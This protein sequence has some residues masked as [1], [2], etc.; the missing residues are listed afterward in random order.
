MMK[1]A[2]QSV[3]AFPQNS[4]LPISILVS[5]SARSSVVQPL[6]TVSTAKLVFRFSAVD[7][8]LSAPGISDICGSIV[9]VRTNSIAGNI[10]TNSF[11]PSK[12]G[13]LYYIY[14]AIYVYVLVANVYGG[15]YKL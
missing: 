12:M 10:T 2:L 6:V 4:L 1:N 11:P 3:L 14:L 15:L 7:D 5:T 8:E 13:G 9:Q